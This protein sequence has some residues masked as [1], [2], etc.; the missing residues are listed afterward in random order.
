MNAWTVVTC[1][2]LRAS[3]V[4][5]PRMSSSCASRGRQHL[6]RGGR[7]PRRL[8]RAVVIDIV[9]QLKEELR[10]Q[11]P[12]AR[13]AREAH[14]RQLPKPI[15]GQRQQGRRNIKVIICVGRSPPTP[16]ATS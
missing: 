14:G 11:I 12:Q 8:S 4:P 9:G 1:A 13:A 3:G 10:G 16:H 6:Q 7:Q 2:C 15:P 5:Q